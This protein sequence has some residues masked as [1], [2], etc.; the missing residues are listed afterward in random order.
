MAVATKAR[1]FSGIKPS[2]DIHL[3]NYLGAV[4]RWVDDQDRYDNIYCVVDLHA[5]TVPFEPDQLRRRQRDTTPG[6]ALPGGPVIPLLAV[7]LAVWLLT[8]LSATQA[9]AGGFGLASGLAIYAGLA[10]AMRLDE[11]RPLVRMVAGRFGRREVQT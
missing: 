5:M 9:I 1:T 8:G 2:G 6:F 11:F 3:G 10:A 4:K 7:A